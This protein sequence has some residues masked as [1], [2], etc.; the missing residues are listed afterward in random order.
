[1]SDKKAKKVVK[2][3]DLEIKEFEKETETPQELREFLI[4]GT[5]NSGLKDRYGEI[6]PKEC[7]DF[8]NF[9]KNPI[10][11][12]QHNH[13]LPIGQITEI[14]T[15][16]TG[17]KFVGRIGKEGKK[18]TSL[19]QEVI[20]LIEQG[21]IKSFS[22]G[23]IPKDYDYDRN[24]DVLVYKDVELLEISVVSIPMDGNALM[25]SFN[26]KSYIDGKGDIPMSDS[27]KEEINALKKGFEGMQVSFKNT[28]AELKE[29]MN[30]L[31]KKE[32]T[33]K[34]STEDTE[35]KLKENEE[36]T[37]KLEDSLNTIISEME[38]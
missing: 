20:D 30:F 35:K 36:Y 11:L 29:I 24:A 5:A 2:R 12:Y 13:N 8:G 17:V 6:M 7:W 23:F 33:L 32:E 22:V 14:Y 19:Q 16:E 1:M 27:L 28:N 26:F 34:K 10:M 21:I 3:F 9:Q 31:S 18:K 15:T 4:R 37:K 38:E 25:S